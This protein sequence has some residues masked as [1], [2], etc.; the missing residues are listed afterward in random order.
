MQSPENDFGVMQGLVTYDLGSSK[1]RVELGTF[2][3]T[4]VHVRV[5]VVDQCLYPD[6]LCDPVRPGLSALVHI[7]VRDEEARDGDAVLDGSDVLAELRVHELVLEI[8]TLANRKGHPA[9][10][11]ADPMPE[12]RE[13]LGGKVEVTERRVV[14]FPCVLDR[15]CQGQRHVDEIGPETV[16][17]ILWC[18]Y[19]SEIIQ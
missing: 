8:V 17:G 9:I 18:L 19:Q 11:E 13:R 15:G 2:L 4:L 10:E 3:V 12:K 14:P 5:E 1:R 16:V 7:Y 6:E